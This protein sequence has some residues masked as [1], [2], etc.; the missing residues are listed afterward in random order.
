[1]ENKE[2]CRDQYFALSLTVLSLMGGFFIAASGH[3][4]AG[5]VFGASGIVGIVGTFIYGSKKSN[6]SP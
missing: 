6:H 5:S 2:V 3:E 1:M 4:I